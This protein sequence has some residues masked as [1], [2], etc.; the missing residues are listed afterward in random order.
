MNVDNKPSRN[1]NDIVV[2][3][4]ETSDLSSGSLDGHSC[5]W[6]MTRIRSTLFHLQITFTILLQDSLFQ[7]LSK[8]TLYDV[9]ALFPSG[10][11]HATSI[12]EVPGDP[13]SLAF[14][15]AVGLEES[16]VF[17]YNG[18]FHR[19][20]LI[21]TYL[22]LWFLFLFGLLLDYFNIEILLDLKK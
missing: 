12:V 16:S 5:R 7:F 14:F 21:I 17:V 6:P 2:I 15:G 11:S 20:L 9:A 1:A 10:A 22:L 13:E 19:Q 18:I 8:H 4:F 3:R